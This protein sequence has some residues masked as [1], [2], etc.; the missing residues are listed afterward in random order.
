MKPL[1]MKKKIKELKKR[2]GRL[3]KALRPANQA[4]KYREVKT[5]LAA[6][7]E[8]LEN[9]NVFDVVTSEEELNEVMPK[10]L[11]SL[12]RYSM[13]ERAYIFTWA[14]EKHQVLRMTHEWCADGVAPT[15]GEM[16]ALKMSD[17]P[18]WAPRL[19]RGEAIVSMDWEAEKE[20]TPEEYAVV[21]GQDIHSLIVIPI[22]AMTANAFAEDIVQS[23]EAGMNEHLSKPLNEKKIL[24][25]IRR[26]VTADR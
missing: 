11:A 26:Y 3:K 10:L 15:I 24:D 2:Q 13:S 4:K 20:H 22:F 19:N 23:R 12:G 16:Q 6:V 1:T 14:S 25:T 5:A 17:M 18:N 9:I 21:D 8:V 7:D